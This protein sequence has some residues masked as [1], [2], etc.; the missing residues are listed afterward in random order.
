MTKT[1]SEAVHNTYFFHVQEVHLVGTRIEVTKLEMI[2][3]PDGVEE[4]VDAPFPITR[5]RANNITTAVISIVTFRLSQFRCLIGE[6]LTRP[7]SR[8][9]TAGRNILMEIGLLEGDE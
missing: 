5:Q 2:E 3:P 1:H 8:S 9:P 7:Y 4:E 6:T